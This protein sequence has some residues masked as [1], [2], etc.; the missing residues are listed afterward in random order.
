ML[1]N[2]N[3]GIPTLQKII[4]VL[5]PSFLTAGAATVLFFTVFDPQEIL[6]CTDG[7]EISRVGA[8]SL[9][10]FLFWLLTSFSCL[11]AL[12]FQKPCPRTGKPKL[13]TE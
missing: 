5:W 13:H 7:L 1:N 4:A 2:S 6:T 9:G 3:T 12:Y 11:L 8:Y 10:F